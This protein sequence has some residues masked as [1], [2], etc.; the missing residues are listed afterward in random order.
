M[1]FALWYHFSSKQ[2]QRLCKHW[3]KLYKPQELEECVLQEGGLTWAWAGDEKCGGV[4]LDQSQGETGLL[5][6]WGLNCATG[7]AG[8]FREEDFWEIQR[9]ELESGQEIP[10]HSCSGTKGVL[11]HHGALGPPSQHFQEE[12]LLAT[13]PV[14]YFHMLW[15][16]HPGLES[17]HLHTN[18][19]E[20]YFR[21]GFFF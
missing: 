5:L 20:S 1:I 2:L 15:T 9:P 10:V 7:Q 16:T 3:F 17:L 12:S 14:L 11:G 19:G 21:S 4:L 18:K 6:Q 13:S 8:L